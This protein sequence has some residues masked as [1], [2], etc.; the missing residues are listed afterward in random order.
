[1]GPRLLRRHCGRK[2]NQEHQQQQRLSTASKRMQQRRATMTAL[3]PLPPALCSRASRIADFSEPRGTSTRF[4]SCCTRGLSQT[5]CEWSLVVVHFLAL[6]FFVFAPLSPDTS[7]CRRAPS[8]APSCDSGRTS[9]QEIGCGFGHRSGASATVHSIS[10]E[11]RPLL[12]H[13]KPRFRKTCC[14][15]SHSMF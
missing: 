10:R 6:A 5:R 13:S 14:S 9:G 4:Y 15:A 12:R 8:G 3:A 1:M 11:L 7:R 2:R